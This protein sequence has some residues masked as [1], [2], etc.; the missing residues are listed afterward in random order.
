MY[1]ED[2]TVIG[3]RYLYEIVLIF[4]LQRILSLLV[5]S[6]DDYEEL[7]KRFQEY[8]DYDDNRYHYMRVMQNAIKEVR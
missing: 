8:L 3:T 2:I 7:L 6:E 4:T 5:S 1:G